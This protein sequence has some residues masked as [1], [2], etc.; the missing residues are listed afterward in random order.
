MIESLQTNASFCLSYLMCFDEKKILIAIK[1][2]SS[3]NLINFG[4]KN[5]G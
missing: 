5:A 3:C 4:I 2:E 1:K